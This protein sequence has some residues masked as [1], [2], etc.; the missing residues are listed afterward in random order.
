MTDV[1][2]IVRLLRYGMCPAHRLS[3]GDKPCDVCATAVD[4]IETVRAMATIDPRDLEFVRDSGAALRARIADL[5]ARLARAS[6]RAEAA[7]AAIELQ[8]SNR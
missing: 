5:E 4:A 2:T 7:E 8:R 6:V 3:S 1:E